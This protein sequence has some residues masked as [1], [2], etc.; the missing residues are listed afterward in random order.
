MTSQRDPRP[1]SDLTGPNLP[2]AMR[3]STTGKPGVSCSIGTATLSTQAW[4]SASNQ[5]EIWS[6]WTRCSTA[7]QRGWNCHVVQGLYSEWMATGSTG[8]RSWKTERR[9]SCRLI[10]LLRL[11]FEDFSAQFGVLHTHVTNTSWPRDVSVTRESH[12][13]L[14]KLSS[15]RLFSSI[16]NSLLRFC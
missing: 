6:L 3:I 8:L 12:S 2:A 10:R 13:D 4:N 7:C 16:A 11:V 5:A 14:D 1:Q 15:L 9:T